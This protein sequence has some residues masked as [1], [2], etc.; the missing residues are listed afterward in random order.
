MQQ[1]EAA[2]QR[3]QSD[4]MVRV[5]GVG[6]WDGMDGTQQTAPYNR[7]TLIGAGGRRDPTTSSQSLTEPTLAMIPPPIIMKGAGQTLLQFRN[8]PQAVNVA[9]HVLGQSVCQS[10]GGVASRGAGV[11]WDPSDAE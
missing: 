4:P 1:F 11:R 2:C 9:R 5:C 10:S 8:D 7:I 3:L 6:E